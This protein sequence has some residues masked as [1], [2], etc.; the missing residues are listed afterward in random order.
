MTKLLNPRRKMVGSSMTDTQTPYMGDDMIENL[1]IFDPSSD[2]LTQ[3]LIGASGEDVDG[4]FSSDE[5]SVTDSRNIFFCK[6][7]S[8]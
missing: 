6:S 3:M 8:R 2:S 1:D 4:D 7:I 5:Q